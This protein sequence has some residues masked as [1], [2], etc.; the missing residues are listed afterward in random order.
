MPPG[1]VGAPGRPQRAGLLPSVRPSV[2]PPVSRLGAR[3]CFR[4]RALHLTA[5]SPQERGP[6]GRI[7]GHPEPVGGRGAGRALQGL[8]LAQ[9][10]PLP[11]RLLAAFFPPTA[12]TGTTGILG[13][14]GSSCRD[15]T[16]TE[17]SRPKQKVTPLGLP[18]LP[19]PPGFPS[20][21]VVNVSHRARRTWL[22]PRAR[23]AG[24]GPHLLPQ[25]PRSRPG[26]DSLVRLEIKH[27]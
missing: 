8:P 17:S 3:A 18:R 24:P 23:D 6:W 10:C 25:L 15:H 12:H 16:F 11:L 21:S 13:V 26:G 19:F 2:R 9:C 14:E 4:G 5:L 7:S 20:S 1:G 22:S 27:I